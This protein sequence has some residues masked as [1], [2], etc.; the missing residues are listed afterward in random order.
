MIAC[1]KFKEVSFHIVVFN[2]ILK[3]F[4]NKILLYLEQIFFFQYSEYLFCNRVI[5][6]RITLF[7]MSSGLPRNL[8]S[9]L[10]MNDFASFELFSCK[11]FKVYF[12]IELSSFVPI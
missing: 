3:R 1:P 12:T 5:A 4:L 2:F 8:L 9:M 10:L 11:I 7:V 6:S